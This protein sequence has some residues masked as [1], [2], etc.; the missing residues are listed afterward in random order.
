MASR[1][2][3]ERTII[4]VVLSTESVT[5]LPSSTDRRRKKSALFICA[6][7]LIIIGFSIP[8][9]MYLNHDHDHDHDHDHEAPS[10]NSTN[11]TVGGTNTVSCPGF[12][13]QTTASGVNVI[14]PPEYSTRFGS[15]GINTAGSCPPA[16]NYQICNRCL[17]M[18]VSLSYVPP[19]SWGVVR[20]YAPFRTKHFT[21]KGWHETIHYFCWHGNLSKQ[22]VVEPRE[23]PVI[24]Q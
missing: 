24:C 20:E 14:C 4:P 7:I 16:N 6:I 9:Y 21:L 8:A 15:Y 11:T 5:S 13:V 12:N 19:S 1:I 3:G 17:S 10:T 2:P 18:G 22:C 23:L